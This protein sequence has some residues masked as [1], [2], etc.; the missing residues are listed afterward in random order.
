[1]IDYFKHQNG[2]VTVCDTEGVIIYMNDM[3]INTFGDKRGMNL[4]A[5]HPPHAQEK[6]KQLLAKGG[7][8]SYTIEKQGKKKI[9]YQTTWQKDDGSIGGLIE[10]S[11]VIPFDM[12]HYIRK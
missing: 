11:F 12:P 10:Y 5:C 2:S 1:M 3:S 8:N 6:I 7:T 9:I 4:F